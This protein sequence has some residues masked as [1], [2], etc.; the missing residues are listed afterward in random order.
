MS[1]LDQTPYP[2][3]IELIGLTLISPFTASNKHHDV[4]C[5]ICNHIWSTTLISKISAYKK[6]YKSGC[7]KCAELRRSDNISNKR[8][9]VIRLLADHHLEVLTDGY[10]G[11]FLDVYHKITVKN[12]VCGHVFDLCVSN[13]LLYGQHEH[14][15]ICTICGIE[16][17][18]DKLTSH[19][20]ERHEIWLRTADEWQQYKSKVDGLTKQTYNSYHHIINPYN[21]PRG[22][23]GTIG[24]Y[25]LDHIISRRYC[26]EHN[27][28][29]ELCAHKD[30]LRMIPW[31]DN[32]KK[33]ALIVT[34]IPSIF[35]D[36][37]TS[38]SIIDNGCF[39][40]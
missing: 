29:C 30:N 32:I 4:Q 31:L 17:R 37:I 11:R 27:I 34:D 39:D 15:N 18:S 1:E 6:Y 20:L 3:K 24:A 21:F 38:P 8:A 33:H 14:K 25:H 23:A 16:Q 7:P 36:Y 26:F 40:E 9:N 28:P 35:S 2:Q 5:N 13:F 10:D 22:L 12:S 19:S